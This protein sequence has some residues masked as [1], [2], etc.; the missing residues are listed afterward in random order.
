VRSRER[1]YCAETIREFAKDA[2]PPEFPFEE[3]QDSV[4]DTVIDT[5]TDLSWPCG[6]RRLNAVADKA[7]LL[8]LTSSPYQYYLKPKSLQGI[9]HQLANLGRL[10]WVHNG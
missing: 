5:A 4:F 6:L 9:C 10:K 2:V 3:V 8:T 1:F 7:A